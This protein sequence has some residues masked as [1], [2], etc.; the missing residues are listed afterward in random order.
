MLHAAK[1]ALVALEKDVHEHAVVR[2]RVDRD[3]SKLDT[4]VQRH[5]KH[6]PRH[7]TCLHERLGAHACMHVL[8]VNPRTR[9][10]AALPSRAPW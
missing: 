8:L 3:I 9:P 5:E 10:S 7:L 2:H 6:A 4:R 1:H